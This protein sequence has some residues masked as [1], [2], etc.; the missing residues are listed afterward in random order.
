MYSLS[1]FPVQVQDDVHVSRSRLYYKK[2]I[3]LIFTFTLTL[4]VHDD[5]HDDVHGDFTVTSRWCNGDVTVRHGNRTELK[6][7]L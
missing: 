6:I 7:L 5:V 3:V 1:N 2:K 4:H